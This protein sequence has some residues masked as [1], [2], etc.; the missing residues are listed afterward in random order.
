MATLASNELAPSSKEGALT[1]MTEV[2]EPEIREQ[3]TSETDPAKSSP[4][5]L[6]QPLPFTDVLLEVDSSEKWRRKL[7]ALSSITLQCL[8][9]GV[10]LVVPLMFT[11]ALPKQQL[12]TMLIGPPPPPPPPPPAAAIPAQIVRHVDSDLMDGGLRTPSRIPQKVE[13]IRETEA[14]APLMTGGGVVGGVPGGIAGGQLGGVIGGIVSSTS[15]LPSLPRLVMEAP[16]RIRVSQ[17][18]V[19]GMVIH[20]VEPT[21]PLLARQARIQGEVMLAAIISKE[22]TIHNLQLVSGHPLLIPAA[23]QAVQQWRY[24]PYLLNGEAVEVETTILVTFR[25]AN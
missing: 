22:G 20:K 13:M 14:P 16:T 11:E 8:M 1:T 9:L 23:P 18:V 21:Y 15:R 6:V 4:L 10:V 12:L 19:E 24:R 5:P 17:G 3:I 2:H 25:F 7:S